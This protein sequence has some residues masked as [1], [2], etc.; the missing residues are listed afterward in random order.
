MESNSVCNH[1]SDNKTGRP[2]SRS[3]VGKI[4]GQPHTTLCIQFL[5]GE[6][7]DKKNTFPLGKQICFTIVWSCVEIFTVLFVYH[8]HDNKLS[9]KKNKVRRERLKIHRNFFF[10]ISQKFFASLRPKF[11]SATNNKGTIG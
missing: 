3:P 4:S 2:R 8:E 6:N 11:F 1:T 10:L 9:D 5:D 7:N